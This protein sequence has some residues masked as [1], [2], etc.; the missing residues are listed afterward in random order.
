MLKN[1]ADLQ[2]HWLIQQGKHVE[3]CKEVW[4]RRWG[5][6]YPKYKSA[7]GVQKYGE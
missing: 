1:L 6:E 7:S 2:L 3:A 4:F 5:L